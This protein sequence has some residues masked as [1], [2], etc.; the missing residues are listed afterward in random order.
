MLILALLTSGCANRTRRARTVMAVGGL[1][2]IAG[3]LMAGACS[4]QG[5]RGAHGRS[6]ECSGTPGADDA[7][8]GAAVVAAGSAVMAAGM[9]MKPAGAPSM[10]GYSSPMLPANEAGSSEASTEPSAGTLLRVNDPAAM[11]EPPAKDEP[12]TWPST[13]HAASEPS[14][15]HSASDSADHATFEPKTEH[16]TEGSSD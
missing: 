13:E 4:K 6:S 12:L 11:A 15:E 5:S 1:T 10:A 3:L 14:A 7:L 2:V 16:G 8:K 9:A